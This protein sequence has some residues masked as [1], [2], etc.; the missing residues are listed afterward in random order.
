MLLLGG[1]LGRFLAPSKVITKTV[2]Q[3]VTQ[4]QVKTVEVDKTDYYK[5]KVF[6]ETTTTKPDGTVTK[7]REFIDKSTV[8]KDDQ[9]NTNSQT[10]STT[11]STTQT[12]TIN[13]SGYKGSTKLLVARNLNNLS[14]DIYGLEVDK[15]L[16]GPITVGAFGLTD[17]TLGL[18]L[19]LNF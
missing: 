1:I 9:T 15:K 17:K 19:G 11:N 4:V 7:T 2:T 16:L 18:A 3:T 8:V 5:N 10:N 12:T 6:T 13:S 14:E